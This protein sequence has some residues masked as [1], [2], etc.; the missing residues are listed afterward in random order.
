MKFIR[1]RQNQLHCVGFFASIL[2]MYIFF[3]K[4]DTVGESY[5]ILIDFPNRQ[6]MSKSIDYTID[7]NMTCQVMS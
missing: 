4:M 2:D 1:I 6:K 7:V 5:R 3:L